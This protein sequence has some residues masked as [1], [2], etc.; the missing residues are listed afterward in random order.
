MP[1]SPGGFCLA[2]SVSVVLVAGAAPAA[3]LPGS[4]HSSHTSRE[5]SYI[6]AVGTNTTISNASIDEM[7]RLR[8][9]R[10]S[11]FL[12]FRRAGKAY[13]IEDPATLNEARELFA[14]LRALEPEQEELRRREEAL[15]DQEGE[16]DRREEG[17]DRQMDAASEDDDDEDGKVTFTPLSDAE[18]ERLGSG[19]REIRSRQRE[20]QAAT[21][22]L[23]RQERELDAREDA[24]ERE[25][26]SKLWTLI[27]AAVKKG[28]AKPA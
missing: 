8:G 10:A 27:D 18:Q 26:E 2:L 23:E 19:L 28:V 13:L 15:D 25:A 4:Q 11:N 7:V 12:W 5:D 16:L 17:I 24:I 3:A 6:L 14:P 1:H 9:D 22:E 20:I 21:R